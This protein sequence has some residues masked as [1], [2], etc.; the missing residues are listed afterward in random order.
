VSVGGE[1]AVGVA[2]DLPNLRVVE[3]SGEGVARG[4][5]QYRVPMALCRFGSLHQGGLLGLPSSL[6]LGP[7]VAR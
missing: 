5:K 1:V 2:C 6:M 7:C 4:P 3:M